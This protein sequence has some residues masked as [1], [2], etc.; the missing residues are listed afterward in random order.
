MI[1]TTLLPAQ[2]REQW[3]VA[4]GFAACPALATDIDV[5]VYAIA[6]EGLDKARRVL[7]AHLCDIQYPQKDSPYANVRRKAQFEFE[8]ETEAR[9]AESY[10][11]SFIQIHKVAVICGRNAWRELKPIHVMVTDAPSPGELLAGFDISTHAVAI[12]HDGRVWTNSYTQPGETPVRLSGAN[13]RTEAR[14]QKICARFGHP[15]LAKEEPVGET[16]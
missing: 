6:T 8:E 4:G 1:P 13:A 9:T 2:Y 14:L 5:W 11:Q 3:C 7:L 10:L 15:Y 12:G 16:V